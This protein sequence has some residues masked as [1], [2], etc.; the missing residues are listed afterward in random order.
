MFDAPIDLRLKNAVGHF[1]AW[2]TVVKGLGARG[3]PGRHACDDR[4]VWPAE[5]Q[6][7]GGECRFYGAR[8]RASCPRAP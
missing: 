2:E 1:P 3:L 8:R 7:M 6:A 5:E 4:A